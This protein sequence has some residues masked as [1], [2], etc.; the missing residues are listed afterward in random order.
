[1]I[2]F[3]HPIKR[4]LIPGTVLTLGLILT[5][6]TQGQASGTFAATG[7]MN[8]PRRGHLAVLLNSG[9]VLVVTGVV[10]ATEVGDF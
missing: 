4:T 1:M 6:A 9:E 8:F 5:P 3:W 10:G 7:S 2:H